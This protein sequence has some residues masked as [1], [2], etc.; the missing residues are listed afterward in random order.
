MTPPLQTGGSHGQILTV[1]GG[2]RTS[3]RDAPPGRVRGCRF[4]PSVFP[5]TSPSPAP[6]VLFFSPLPFPRWGSRTA[7]RSE[8]LQGKARRRCSPSPLT[9]E[10]HRRS[11]IYHTMIDVCCGWEA[12]SVERNKERRSPRWRPR[13]ELISKGGSQNRC[14]PFTKKTAQRVQLPAVGGSTLNRG[15]H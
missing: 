5:D 3:L 10:P 8:W 2:F 11:H 6:S 7:R 15:Q 4:G 14:L 9:A 13:W 12:E 1:L